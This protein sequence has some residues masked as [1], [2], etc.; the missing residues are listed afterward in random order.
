LRGPD[1]QQGDKGDVENQREKRKAVHGYPH[2][3]S[4]NR[5]TEPGSEIDARGIIGEKTAEDL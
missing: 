3:R 2:C 5:G 4:W 1:Q